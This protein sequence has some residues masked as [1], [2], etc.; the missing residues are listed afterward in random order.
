MTE[1]ELIREERLA[2]NRQKIRDLF[3]W[4]GIAFEWHVSLSIAP[5]KLRSRKPKPPAFKP[6]TVLRKA[7]TAPK[8]LMIPK[9]A[10][11]EPK[12]SRERRHSTRHLVRAFL[13]RLSK[14]FHISFAAAGVLV[15][16]H[17]KA[18]HAH[19]L[20]V[21]DPR[22]RKRFDDLDKRKVLRKLWPHGDGRITTRQQWRSISQ[23]P[24]AGKNF[25]LD[26]TKQEVSDPIYY[27]KPL[28]DALSAP[29]SKT[30]FRT[31]SGAN[32]V[33]NTRTQTFLTLSDRRYE[34]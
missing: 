24:T 21:S 26:G 20:L 31:S 33:R 17:G 30:T 6:R 22:K 34:S 14:E 13:K 32:I 16:R 7:G 25:N 12:P 27:R 18:D 5:K 9:P 29:K 23:Y 1:A 8:P 15:Y 3:G 2:R 19:L 4:D 28:L 11:L 10:P